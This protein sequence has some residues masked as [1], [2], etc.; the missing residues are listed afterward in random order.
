[1][2]CGGEGASRREE[3]GRDDDDEVGV[4]GTKTNMEIGSDA[5]E[6]EGEWR[7]SPKQRRAGSV[8]EECERGVGGRQVEAQGAVG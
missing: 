7:L 1:V 6:D 5:S 8:E 4:G 3:S 2:E